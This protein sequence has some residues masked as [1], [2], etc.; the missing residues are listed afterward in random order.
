M[1]SSLVSLH[2]KQCSLMIDLFGGAIV[3]FHL[4][5]WGVN[6]LNFHFVHRDAHHEDVHYKGHFLCVPRWG[7]PSAAEIKAGFN[8]HGDFVRLK[9]NAKVDECS[10]DMSAFSLLENLAITRTIR[11]DEGSACFRIIEKL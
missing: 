3:D 8:K 9:W 10:I 7:D 11:L 4:G 5:D 6:P 1:D 2:N